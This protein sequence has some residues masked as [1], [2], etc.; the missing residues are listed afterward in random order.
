MLLTNQRKLCLG[1]FKDLKDCLAKIRA[2]RKTEE[3]KHKKFINKDELRANVDV[4]RYN[5]SLFDDPDDTND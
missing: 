4:Y 5:C 2:D 3:T 1:P